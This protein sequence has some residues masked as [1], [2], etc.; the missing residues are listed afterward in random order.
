[1]YCGALRYVQRCLALDKR[2]REDGAPGPPKEPQSLADLQHAGCRSK[3]RGGLS[4]GEEEDE[5]IAVHLV[6]QWST[7]GRRGGSTVT[8]QCAGLALL[9]CLSIHA[10]LL[11]AAPLAFELAFDQ[12]LYILYIYYVFVRV[13]I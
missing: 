12:M 11:T 1:M 6:N 8:T 5:R 4:G 13:S 7:S 2:A 3:G 10:H 9:S